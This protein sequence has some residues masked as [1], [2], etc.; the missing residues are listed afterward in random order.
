MLPP[1]AGQFSALQPMSVSGARSSTVFISPDT[2]DQ[3]IPRATRHYP[4]HHPGCLGITKKTG[5]GIRIR[6]NTVLLGPDPVPGGSIRARMYRFFALIVGGRGFH[7]TTVT[8]SCRESR[9][10]TVR[11]AFLVSSSSMPNN[12]QIRQISSGERRSRTEHALLDMVKG[13]RYREYSLIRS[14]YRFNT[15]CRMGPAPE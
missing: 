13:N 9:A 15:F 11:S 8:G 1:G 5:D 4:R 2:P 3:R 6:Q 12:V 7:S 10:H 14:L